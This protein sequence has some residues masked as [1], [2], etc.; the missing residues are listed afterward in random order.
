MADRAQLTSAHFF[1]GHDLLGSRFDR[2]GS[3]RDDAD[4][5]CPMT[6]HDNDRC[7]VHA[8][9]SLCYLN[10]DRRAFAERNPKCDR[11]WFRAVN[12]SSRRSR[13]NNQVTVGGCDA[14]QAG[15]NFEFGAMLGH[16]RDLAGFDGNYTR[17]TV[18]SAAT[19]FDFNSVGRGEI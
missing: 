4:E 10:V 18:T 7:S 6:I 16:V 17:A 9:D 19:R 11:P 3:Y 1:W 15:A 2:E 8:V 14:G 5:A 13:I 12:S